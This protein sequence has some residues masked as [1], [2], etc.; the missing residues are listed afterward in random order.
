MCVLILFPYSI[1]ALIYSLRLSHLLGIFIHKQFKV[2]PLSA[3]GSKFLTRRSW[4]KLIL[5]L[6]IISSDLSIPHSLGLPYWF[7]PIFL[8]RV[9]FSL[10]PYF[11]LPHVLL[12]WLMSTQCPW[13]QQYPPTSRTCLPFTH[14]GFAW[15]CLYTVIPDPLL[16]TMFSWWSFWFKAE[17]VAVMSVI[18]FHCVIIASL[19][20]AASVARLMSALCVPSISLRLFAPQYPPAWVDTF[21]FLLYFRCASWK[22]S[23]KLAQ[24]FSSRFMSSHLLQ[25]S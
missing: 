3:I 7:P 14:L 1:R 15:P 23:W 20:P 17:T 16:Y 13:V 11:F 25:L 22:C 8:A 18:V 9:A 5:V 2:D 10:W 6:L 24:V 4:E 21:C 12:S 19:L